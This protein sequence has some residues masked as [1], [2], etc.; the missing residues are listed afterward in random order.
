[1]TE[2][3]TETTHRF[4]NDALYSLHGI[5]YLATSE[6]T[7]VR[8][9]GDRTPVTPGV[10]DT[11]EFLAEEGSE[12]WNWRMRQALQRANQDYLNSDRAFRALTNWAEGLKQALLEKAVD[13]D[14]CSEYD[15]FA[16]EWDL[17][18]RTRQYTVTVEFLVD[19]TS[20]D[21]AI[22]IATEGAHIPFDNVEFGASVY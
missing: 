20:E 4:T 8:I 2:T 18:L 13:K 22:D 1:M 9:I 3:P 16:E 17:P 14:W 19:A 10:G 5:V 7:L 15:E 21:D 12:G 6:T 11:V